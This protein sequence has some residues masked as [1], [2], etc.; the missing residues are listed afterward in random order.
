[1][2]RLTDPEVLLRYKQALADWKV[3][4]AIELEGR[5]P[6]GLRTTLEGV[7]IKYFKEALYRYVCEENGEIDQVKEEREPWC[8][9]WEWRYDLRLTINGVNVYVETRLYPESFS[10]LRE[11]TVRVVQVKPA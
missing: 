8:K 2:T 7:T 11:P 3:A 4:G 9:F 5:A 10:S 6:E 1:M